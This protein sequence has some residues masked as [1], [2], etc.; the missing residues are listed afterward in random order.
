MTIILII[1][2][3]YYYVRQSGTFKLNMKNRLGADYIRV[4]VIIFINLTEKSN[5]YIGIFIR[6][7]RL[8]L[9]EITSRRYK[10]NCKQYVLSKLNYFNLLMSHNKFR[11]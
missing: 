7:N 11:F 5:S 8:I 1:N 6:L 4:Y 2:L 3:Y 10:N 9:N